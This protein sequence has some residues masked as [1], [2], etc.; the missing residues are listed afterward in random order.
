VRGRSQRALSRG[1]QG[2]K[3]STGRKLNL[4]RGRSGRVFADRYHEEVLTTPTQVRNCVAYVLNNW[5][6]HREDRDAGTHVDPFSTGMWFTGWAE[7]QF[8]VPPH[9]EVLPSARPQTWLLAEGYKK[10]KPI[11][12]YEV[13]GPRSGQSPTETMNR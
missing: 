9:L 10:A 5:R 4:T 12:L 3:I 7:R 11:S 2:F 13:P 6:R 8:D 1:I